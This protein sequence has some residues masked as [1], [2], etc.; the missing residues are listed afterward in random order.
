M[1]PRTFG[2]LSAL[3]PMPP[4]PSFFTCHRRCLCHADRQR[5]LVREDPPCPLRV[6]SF[7]LHRIYRANLGA[8]PS[9]LSHKQLSCLLNVE[10]AKSFQIDLTNLHIWFVLCLEEQMK[11]KMLLFCKQSKSGRGPGRKSVLFREVAMM[12]NSGKGLGNTL[13][14]WGQ[15]CLQAPVDYV[16]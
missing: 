5:P 15:H 12:P 7:H 4:V 13:L 10:P 2:P 8:V 14:G 16:G 6:P 9:M 3:P 1:K 11:T